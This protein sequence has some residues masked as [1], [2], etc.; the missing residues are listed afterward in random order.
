MIKFIGV[1]TIVGGVALGAMVGSGVL[2]FNAT[3]K[4]TPKGQAQVQELRSSAADM[5]RGAGKATAKA[6][7]NASDAAADAAQ[8]SAQK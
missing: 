3:A 5:V 2:D 4:V 8:G 6:A 1:V 7:K